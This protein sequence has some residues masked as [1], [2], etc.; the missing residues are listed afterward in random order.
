MLQTAFYDT[1]IFGPRVH[2][3]SRPTPVHEIGLATY[4]DVV[5]GESL[6]HPLEA[7]ILHH[8]QGLLDLI[9]INF[10]LQEYVYTERIYIR[11]VN[12]WNIRTPGHISVDILVG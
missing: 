10:F 7:S 12:M 3:G 1:V 8:L 2:P 5:P 4:L 11:V 9:G 6:A